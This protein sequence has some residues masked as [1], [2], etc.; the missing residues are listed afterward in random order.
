MGGFQLRD[1]AVA[2]ERLFVG[3]VRMT[4]V[5]THRKT[6]GETILAQT[7]R[8]RYEIGCRGERTLI[9]PGE[10]ALIPAGVP[11]E[12]VH[13]PDPATGIMEAR[14]MHVHA[15]VFGAVDLLGLYALPLRVDR[16]R[17]APLGEVIEALLAPPVPGPAGALR[18]ALWRNEH[19]F[20][21]LRLLADLAP[22]KPDAAATL[23]RGAA[24]AP[25]FR[26]I[27]LH[28]AESLDIRRLAGWAAL[29]PSRLHTL[30][31][32]RFGLTPMAYVKRLRLAEARRLLAGTA[33]SVKEVAAATGFACPFHFSRAF[34]AESRVSPSAYRAQMQI[35]GSPARSA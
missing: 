4:E 23:D 19:G 6:V 35:T 16:D 13:L 15:T 31:Q 28:L 34:K 24:L 26:A 20:N 21:T 17:A 29:S 30:F 7:L 18:Q 5:V 22:L 14:W 32:A 1:D 2:I 10:L 11:V 33:L 12:F 25:L 9:A 27:R 3:R 8:G